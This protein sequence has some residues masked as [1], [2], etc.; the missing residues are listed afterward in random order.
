M[1][2]I[3]KIHDESLFGFKGNVNHSW[4]CFCRFE[5]LQQ[6]HQGRLM[7]TIPYSV[8]PMQMEWIVCRIVKM[9]VMIESE[10]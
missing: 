4:F 3:Q 5:I 1:N 9:Y 10:F 7:E 2:F 8:C 6:Q